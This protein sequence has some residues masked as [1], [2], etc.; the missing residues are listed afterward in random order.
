MVETLVAPADIHAQEYVDNPQVSL[1]DMLTRIGLEGL[2]QEARL[3]FIERATLEDYKAAA[4]A[5][6]KK[7]AP[8]HSHDEHPDAVKITDPNTGEIRHYTAAPSERDSILGKA[9]ESAQLV[10][11]K[12]R[13]EGGSLEDALQRCSNLA[14]F[15]LVLAHRYENGNGRTARTMGELIHKGYDSSD[16]E[17]VQD[18][19]TVSA[20]RPDKGFRINSYVPSGEWAD[21]AN[22]QPLE[23]LDTVAAL[24][25]P[26]DDHSY[27]EAS[28]GMF[29]TPR[30]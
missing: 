19:L 20:N 17:S 10:A 13:S 9:L 26:L 24:E 29:T 30:M 4:D 8:E 16:P 7:V 5:L 15:G 14:A 12:Y 27:K 23:F 28:R 11:A 1:G 3:A 2:S 22:A 6:H 18:L 21:H 25:Q